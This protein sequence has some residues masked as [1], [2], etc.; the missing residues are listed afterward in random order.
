V[1]VRTEPRVLLDATAIPGERG[2]V[3]RYVDNL[4][5]ALDQAGAALSVVCQLPDAEIFSALAPRSRIIPVADELHNR[6]ARLAWEQAT[7]SRL[8]KRLPVDLIHSPHYTMPLTSALPVVTTLHDAT[9]FSDPGLHIGVKGKF[10]RAWTRTSLRRAAICIVPSRATADELVRLA[11]ARRE[12]LLVAHL[13]VDLER[14]HL[15]TPAEVERVRSFL[16][17][18]DQGWVTFLGTL[19]PRKNVPALIRAFTRVCAGRPNPPTLVLAGSPGWDPGVRPALAAVPEGVRVLQTGHLPVD[20]LPGLLGGALAV[21]YPSLGEG[22]GLPVLEA[23]ACGAAVLT[24]RRLSLPEVGGD[25]VA[26]SGTGAGDIAAELAALLDDPAR[27]AELAAAALT[28]AGTFTWAA[29]AAAHQLAYDRAA[30]M[31]P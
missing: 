20:L 23:M 27:R 18:G 30:A 13:G 14:F 19:E 10:F 9:F 17:L 28:R 11:H 24:T 16:D 29:T 12:R 1:G 26:Y 3:G 7:L 8:A 5:H 2:G 15:P 25:A 22:F 6:P 31:A 21:C 4:A